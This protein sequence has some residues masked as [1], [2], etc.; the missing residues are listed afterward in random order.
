MRN[1]TRFYRAHRVQIMRTTPGHVP[2][3]AGKD[4]GDLACAPPGQAAECQEHDGHVDHKAHFLYIEEVIGQLAPYILHGLI[5]F[6]ANL[7]ETSNARLH[8]KALFVIR[9]FETE[10]LD[11]HRAFGARPD[12][13]H[14]AAKDVDQ[15]RNLVDMRI[16][17]ESPQSC[18]TWVVC[19]RPNRTRA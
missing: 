12:K 16:P 7:S 10:S 19:H 17:K 15:L 14:F 5:V 13:A 11:E 3:P 6:V 18:D 4:N 9:Y 1:P 2:A 8:S